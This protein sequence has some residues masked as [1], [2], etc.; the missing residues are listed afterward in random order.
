LEKGGRSRIFGRS[1]VWG[2]ESS[3]RLDIALLRHMETH[4]LEIMTA[5][6]IVPTIPSKWRASGQRGARGDVSVPGGRQSRIAEVQQVVEPESSGFA[7]WRVVKRFRQEKA[8]IRRGK[9]RHPRNIY[10][11]ILPKMQSSV[12]RSLKRTSAPMETMAIRI[13]KA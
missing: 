11:L 6:Q 2:G 9:Q 13:K 10:T 3:S 8:K 1:E 4:K 12:T 5:M 7:L